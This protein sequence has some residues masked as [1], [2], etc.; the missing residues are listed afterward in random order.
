[1]KAPR[2]I[3]HST[4]ARTRAPRYDGRQQIGGLLRFGGRLSSE[5]YLLRR[6]KWEARV[7]GSDDLPSTRLRRR[8]LHA[9]KKSALHA[10]LSK[11]WRRATRPRAFLSGCT[12][13][14]RQSRRA[15]SRLKPKHGG[16]H[17]HRN[18]RRNS[19]KRMQ[20]RRRAA[21]KGAKPRSAA[22]CSKQ[23]RFASR[24]GNARSYSYDDST[25]PLAG[26]RVND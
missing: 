12:V 5:V 16:S 21:S 17:R 24:C 15:R 19:Q 22:R 13:A 25:L 8:S 1:M 9:T 2:K 23:P 7:V 6:R 18:Q 10:F 14:A 4:G 3:T 26:Y 20:S 11:T